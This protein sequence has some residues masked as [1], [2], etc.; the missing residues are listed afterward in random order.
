MPTIGLAA[1]FLSKLDLL[2]LIK[3][4]TA[5]FSRRHVVKI[6]AVPTPLHHDA[7]LPVLFDEKLNR[8]SR[9]ALRRGKLEADVHFLRQ[10]VEFS[11][12]ILPVSIT[13]AAA[14]QSESSI[15]IAPRIRFLLVLFCPRRAVIAGHRRAAHPHFALT[16]AIP[17]GRLS[18]RSKIHRADATARDVQFAG[19]CGAEP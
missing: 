13:T 6:H 17:N 8:K 19:K 12:K 16:R 18:L 3:K 11:P 1:E 14:D 10:R 9:R 7:A 2:W 4:R 5:L 15:E